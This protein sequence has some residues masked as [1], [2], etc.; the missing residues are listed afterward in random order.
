MTP[1]EVGVPDFDPMTSNGA[2]TAGGDDHLLA[3]C[4]CRRGDSGQRGRLSRR[5][6]RRG[7]FNDEVPMSS[8]SPAGGIEGW[9]SHGREKEV[10]AYPLRCSVP[11]VHSSFT[12]CPA[13][14]TIVRCLA[15]AG[16]WDQS[17]AGATTLTCLVE[18]VTVTS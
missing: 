6:V 14:P 5:Q 4:A 18:P 3:R 11:V 10:M 8:A 9:R 15:V 17:R 1:A 7:I 13:T 12:A 16:R 2:V